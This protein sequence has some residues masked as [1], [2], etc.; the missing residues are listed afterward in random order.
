MRPLEREDAP[1]L[2]GY[3][4]NPAVRRTLATYRPITVAQEQ[5]RLEALTSSDQDVALGVVLRDGDILLGVTG[6]HRLDFRSHQAEFGLFIGDS[7]HW[8]KGLGTET[9]RLMLDYG[10]G[11]LNLNKV[12]LQV[13][14]HHTSAQRVYEKAGFRREGVQREQYFVEGRYVDG[15][16]MGIL[17][18]EWTPLL[19][20]LREVAKEA[21]SR[22]NRGPYN[23]TP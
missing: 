9:T 3:L 6:L 10:F 7:T 5:A 12:W 17:R 23:V 11:T 21:S 20:E 16:L 22:Q 8:G 1:R 2:A 14:G 4:N 15:I 19:P 18:A 13:Y